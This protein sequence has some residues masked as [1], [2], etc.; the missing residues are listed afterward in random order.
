MNA[1]DLTFRALT[2]EELVTVYH[3]RMEEDFPQDELKPLPM[4]EGLVAQ[5][6]N[7]VIGCFQEDILIGYYV[8][9]REPGADL[10]LLDY[11]AVVP[12]RRGQGYGALILAHL[13]KELDEG[14]YLFI[15]S[16]NPEKAQGDEEQR[17]RS[18]RVA[19]YQRCGAKLTNLRVLL[20]GV[21]FYILVLSR[22]TVPD[23]Y[24]L[25]RAYLSLYCQMI[26]EERCKQ[27]VKTSIL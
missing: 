21:D 4:L 26:S 5:G 3:E 27:H 10:I 19:F 7:S 15:E 1:S 6:I 22:G 25:E 12:E 8:L 14:T 18:H 13:R 11:L 23:E 17:V 16:E 24:E 9:G 20:F 2:G